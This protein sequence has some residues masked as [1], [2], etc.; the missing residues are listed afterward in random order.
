MAKVNLKRVGKVMVDFF[1]RIA[2]GEDPYAMCF[3]GATD[4]E[5]DMARKACRRLCRENGVKIPKTK[6]A[7]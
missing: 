7:A 6:H 4:K 1:D 5:I 3:Y 2:N